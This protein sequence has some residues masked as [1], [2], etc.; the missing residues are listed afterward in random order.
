MFFLHD[1]VKK[2]KFKNDRKL[3]FLLK[4]IITPAQFINLIDEKDGYTMVGPAIVAKNSIKE[5]ILE[6]KMRKLSLDNAK[7]KTSFSLDGN[8]LLSQ[9][10]KAA[11]VFPEI[12][13]LV[14]DFNAHLKVSTCI[15]CTKRHYLGR[16]AKELIPL[17][18]TRD[19]ADVAEFIDAL[20]A[21]YEMSSSD[22]TTTEYDA[23]WLKPEKMIGLGYDLVKNL[24]NCFDCVI[25]H[26]GRAKALYEE[27]TLGYPDVGS[28]IVDELDKGLKSIEQA[29]I[30][31]LDSMSQLDMAS[32]ELVGQL[33]K[34]PKGWEVDMIELANEIR[35][36]RLLCQESPYTAPDFDTLRLKVKKL[37]LKTKKE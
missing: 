7:E 36:A 34:L 35:S 18:E 14:S 15:P 16:I 11:E 9:L 1:S 31:Y 13:A 25:K 6:W 4:G 19:Y 22:D 17:S 33:D 29:Y 3:N 12:S 26:L 37:E 24:G 21:R 2:K 27:F 10:D 20:K 32:C 5:F 28:S 8:E 23:E 30:A